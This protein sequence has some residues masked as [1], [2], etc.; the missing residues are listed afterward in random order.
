MTQQER[1]T[2]QADEA[3]K[4]YVADFDREY[5]DYA[6]VDFAEGFL[7]GLAA[8][9]RE[10]AGSG[11]SFKDLQPI[12]AG[13]FAFDEENNIWEELTGPD[14]PNAVAL[15]QAVN[16]DFPIG[17]LTRCRK[18]GTQ[19]SVKLSYATYPAQPAEPVAEA[20]SAH[21]SQQVIID[22][23]AKSIKSLQQ[24][25]VD[26]NRDLDDMQSAAVIAMGFYKRSLGNKLA[27][28]VAQLERV[29]ER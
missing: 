15:Y 21:A 22:E 2:T 8:A 25:L 27:P 16:K 17:A 6:E 11:E 1:D 7:A 26:A 28:I 13:Y 10:V 14:A 3:A 24:Q 23:Q 5:R 19:T 20:V 12:P 18:C 9:R 4:I 29:L